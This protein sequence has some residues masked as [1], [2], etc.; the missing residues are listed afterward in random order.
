MAI[1]SGDSV[2]RLG[3][4]VVADVAR[5]VSQAAS[6]I[7]RHAEPV[8]AG[9]AAGRRRARLRP[10]AADR[11]RGAS[12]SHRRAI[13]RDRGRPASLVLEPV[14]RN[15][16]P[17]AAVA[18]LRLAADDR[19]ALMLV[20]PSDHTIE[21]RRAFLAAVER[22]GRGRPRRVCWS[23][24]AST[25]RVP[26]PAMA[27]SS[28]ASRSTGVG[29]PDGAFAVARFV[30]KPDAA[31]AERDV[32]AGDFFWNSGIF[33]FLR[34]ALSA[35]SWSGCGRRCRPPACWRST[36][37]GAT[38]ILSASTRRPSPIVFARV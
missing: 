5:A 32:A 27:I 8:A 34:G 35:A 4:P 31:T 15:T 28:A 3:H 24:L 37:R 29:G 36:G 23:P 13:A 19:N 26:R 22:R 21:D 38:T 1:N 12:F 9:G 11:Q 18:A 30:E 25:P 14:G 33:L 16:A 7:G 6:G 17:A 2:R 20:M 10:A